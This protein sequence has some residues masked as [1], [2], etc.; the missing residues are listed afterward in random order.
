MTTSQSR[1]I[2]TMCPMNCHPTF[3]GMLAEVKDGRLIDITGDKANPDSEGFLCVRGQAAREIIDNPK[4]LLH[5][6]IRHRRG[7][8]AWQRASWDDAYDLICSKMQEVGR[9]AVALWPGHGNAVN[10]YGVGVKWQLIE[11]F[12]NLYGCQRW[13]PAMIC[14][15]LGG[16]GLGLTGAL[17]TSTKEDM[18]AN[19]EM[20]VL[21]AANLTSQPNTA[22]YLVAAKR[23]GA[24]IVT[25]DVR[26][27]EAAAQSDEVLLLRPGSDSALALALMHVIISEDLYD[28]DFVRDHT[29][30]FDELAEH[31]RPFTPDWAAQETNIQPERI[32]ALAR[33]YAETK[34]AMMVIG[35]SSLHKGAN[36]WQAA[37][38]VSCLPALT[39]NFGVPGGGI[40]PRHGSVSHG[41]GMANIA[42]SSQRKPGNYI[43]DQ[44]SDIS[45]SLEDGRVRVL[46]TLGSNI[47]SSFP[48]AGRIARGLSRADL[49]V[50]YDI[51]MTDTARRYADV[52]LPGTVWLEE[53]GCKATNT[54]VYLSDRALE[55]AGDTRALYEVLKDL[56]GRLGVDGFY[57]WTSHEDAIDAVLDH[58]ATGHATVASMRANQGRAALKISHVAYPSHRYDTPSGKIE[59]F[60][61]QSEKLGLPP[62][63]MPTTSA[64][65]SYP[66]TLCQ[67]RT[68]THFH[69]FYDQGLALPTLAKLDPRPIL[70]MSVADADLRDLEDGAAI[71]IYNQRGEFEAHAH[72]TDQM[73]DGVVWMRDGWTGL[74]NLTSGEAVVPAQALNLFPFTVGQASFEANVEVEPV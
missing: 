56:A 26:Q 58:P 22:R 30:G 10:D 49:I 69:S 36:G 67:G 6:M 2:H 70:W 48:D 45:A 66:L 68:L 63:P 34:P 28:S 51:F 55:P 41:R 43:A 61:K 9:E 57:P 11:R 59:F 46:L 44:M 29:V 47:L 21:W 60:S 23:R 12:A 50:N 32:V 5:P 35:G 52:I 39:G 8:G 7:E 42:A 3:C 25:I 4:R 54:H 33:R 37:R 74:N 31:V 62:L 65:T 16:F 17:E 18:G 13:S 72:V 14:W 73:T 64:P 38:A 1:T 15:G 20:I 24:H 53:L 40:G 71:R 19:A 27:T